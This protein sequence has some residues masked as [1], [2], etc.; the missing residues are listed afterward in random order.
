MC[1]NLVY[2]QFSNKNM[3]SQKT[4]STLKITIGTILVAFGT[5]LLVAFS[6]GYNFDIFRGEIFSTGL[7]L[8]GTN[9]SGASIK[10]NN[11]S[12][13]Q[14][15]PYRLEN[16][17]TGNLNVEYSKPD[18][19]VWNSSYVVRPGEVT[20]ADYALLLPNNIEQS[21]NFTKLKFDNLITSEERFKVYAFLNSPGSIYEL[22]QTNNPKK[23]IELPP[24]SAIQPPN[25]LT[26]NLLSRDG[27]AIITRASYE[28][29]STAKFWIDSASAQLV[30]IEALL[31][32]KAS[33][34]KFNQRNSKEFY[35]L[36][37]GKIRRANVDNK[38][39][40]D[41]AASSISSYQLDREYIYTLEN[42][43]P[44]EQGQFLVRYDYN[45]NNRYV[46]AQ[47]PPSTSPREIL[48]SEYNGQKLLAIR[49][50]GE[51]GLYV[52]R[53]S[54]GKNLLS[55]A[56]AGVTLDAFSPN[57]RLLS[58]IQN[59]ILKT[60]DIETGERFSVDSTDTNSISWITN[61][62]LIIS[63]PNGLYMVDFNG[64]NYNKI[65]PNSLSTSQYRYAIKS[66][67]KS[68]YYT[69]DGNLTFFTLQPKGLIN[70]R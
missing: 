12:I 47:L 59:N 25:K 70:F 31:S 42:L 50:T 1:L 28:N 14:K 26:E 2:N 18:Y 62:Q 60:I 16:F 69:L 9:P 57:G 34:I 8:L 13:S 43:N 68:V 44:I 65:P 35:S 63:K 52:Y 36:A 49:S 21:D 61:Y 55:F 46:L 32:Q 24:N 54:E 20:F 15:T 3:I 58:Y 39:I 53:Q 22:D 37:E 29:G 7:V 66:N 33:D 67:D 38:Q 48:A 10:I 64:Y 27:S 17:K 56:G 6:S 5:L 11:K 51:G 45:G 4:R 40:L 23:V 30:D 19:K 41:L